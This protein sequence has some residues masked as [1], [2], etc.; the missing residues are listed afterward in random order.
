[1]NEEA[2]RVEFFSIIDSDGA[3]YFVYLCH[4]CRKYHTV[5]NAGRV[6]VSATTLRRL[7]KDSEELILHCG[8]HKTPEPRLADEGGMIVSLALNKKPPRKISK[9]IQ[10]R[11][12]DI[13]YLSRATERR[14][15]ETPALASMD[16]LLDQQEKA[17]QEKIESLEHD[18]E[19]LAGWRREVEQMEARK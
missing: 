8:R 14:R 1:M 6:K 3:T 18:K 17:L 15:L 7:K 19:R 4:A 10:R 2:R 9:R 5:K 11:I 16:D 13:R 12:Q